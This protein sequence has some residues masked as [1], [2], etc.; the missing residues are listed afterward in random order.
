MEIP[1]QHATVNSN[2]KCL[3]IYTLPL[4]QLCYNEANEEKKRNGLPRIDVQFS[5]GI[6][7]LRAMR[8]G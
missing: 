6:E 5:L 2:L 4:T 1:T 3:Y 7:N 8:H